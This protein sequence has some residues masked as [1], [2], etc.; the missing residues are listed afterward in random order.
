[1]G[2]FG[3]VAAHRPQVDAFCAWC[4]RQA[5]GPALLAGTLL[6][7][8]KQASDTLKQSDGDLSEFDIEPPAEAQPTAEK[9]LGPVAVFDAPRAAALD[10]LGLR[11]G[12]SRLKT[13][14]VSV[15]ATQELLIG[16]YSSSH[17]RMSPR[18]DSQLVRDAVA[19]IRL[20][21]LGLPFVAV[22]G[23]RRARPRAPA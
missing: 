20:S 22:A 16:S 23:T 9:V 19:L 18:T 3:V 12:Q 8:P 4:E 13:L 17:R 10:G 14:V 7:A 1:M 2:I 11:P 15:G 21:R 5:G 6:E